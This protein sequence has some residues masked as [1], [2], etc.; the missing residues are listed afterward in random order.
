MPQEYIQWV[1]F[2]RPELRKIL[3][4]V[5]VE[6]S[7]AFYGLNDT[8]NKMVSRIRLHMPSPG[9]KPNT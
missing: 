5:E 1:S 4:S 6:E 7:T 9:N 8:K 2:E 3:S